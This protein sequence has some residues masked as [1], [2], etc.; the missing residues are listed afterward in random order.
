MANEKGM[1]AVCEEISANGKAKASRSVTTQKGKLPGP[2]E[3]SRCLTCSRQ[4]NKSSTLEGAVGSLALQLP[5]KILFFL[6]HFYF[7]TR[8]LLVI[9]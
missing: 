3:R 4:E 7:I 6:A 9:A 1:W 2:R 5:S 8:I